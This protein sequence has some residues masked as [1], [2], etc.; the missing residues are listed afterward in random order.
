MSIADEW[1]VA[2][3]KC[4]PE[5]IKSV[6]PEFY[7]F[8]NGLQGVKSSH[9]L[10]R[11]RV[12]DE[13]VFSFRVM[14]EPKLKHVIKSK[15]A[16]KLGTLLSTAKFAVEPPLD[17]SLQEFVAWKPEKKVAES[18][19]QKFDDFT[20]FLCSLSKLAV[21]MIEKGY[22]DTN[23]R[24][25]LARAMASMLGCTEYGSLS[26]KSIEVGYYDRITNKYSAHMK[27]NF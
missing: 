10:I 11:D 7:H 15:L 6:L 9:F 12:D 26:P 22:F 2:V 21:D 17:N 14:V 24:V 5:E 27:E 25:E 20:D 3:F 13:A 8:V 16:Y 4:K 1:C 18:G 19:L 23:E